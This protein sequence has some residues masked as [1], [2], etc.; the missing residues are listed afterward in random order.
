MAIKTFT[1]GEVL[2]A[3]DTNEYLANSGLVYVKSQTV[4]TTVSSVTVSD[5]F[6]STYD[7]YRVIMS[8]GVGSTSIDFSMQLGSTNSDYYGSVV[9][10]NYNESTARA[11]GT[12]A[13][14]SCTYVGGADGSFAQIIVDINAPNLLNRATTVQGP[15]QNNIAFGTSSYRIATNLQYTAFTIFCNL[16]TI[17]GG[18]ITVYGYRKA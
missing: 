1:T 17:T 4:G 16:G 15:F 10:C 11:I 9:Y 7:N 18:T 12:N 6:S 5:A 14:I 2:T 3:A 8:G 13:G